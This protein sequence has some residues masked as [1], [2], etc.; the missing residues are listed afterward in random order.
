M[1]G[2]VRCTITGLLVAISMKLQ[3]LYIVNSASDILRW[4][5]RPGFTGE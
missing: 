3:S 2:V 4:L 1:G 5:N